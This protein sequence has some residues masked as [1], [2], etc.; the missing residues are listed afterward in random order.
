MRIG[1]IDATVRKRHL[2]ARQVV[3][4]ADRFGRRMETAAAVGR[5]RS[6][7]ARLRKQGLVETTWAESTSGP[8]RRYY[9]LT[10]QGHLALASFQ[11]TWKTFRDA[12]DATL[13]GGHP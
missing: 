10:A 4:A 1:E 12:V 3:E 11:R 6:L 9:S 7:L 13:Q 5:L 2:A 8:P